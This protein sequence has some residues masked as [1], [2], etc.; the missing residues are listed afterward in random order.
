MNLAAIIIQLITLCNTLDL[1]HDPLNTCK[2]SMIR[3]AQENYNKQHSDISNYCTDK[4]FK[5]NK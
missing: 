2:L 4:Y 1:A 5:E 3:C